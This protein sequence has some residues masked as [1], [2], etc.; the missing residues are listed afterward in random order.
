MARLHCQLLEIL[1][2]GPAVALAKGMDV[3]HVA[4]DDAGLLREL[5][6]V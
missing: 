6:G 1:C 4:D 5:I 3:V 2:L